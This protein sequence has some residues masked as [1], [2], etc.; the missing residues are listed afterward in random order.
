MDFYIDFKIPRTFLRKTMQKFRGYFL[1]HFFTPIFLRYFLHQFFYT[2]FFTPIFYI[3]FLR[4]FFYT[5]FL[6]QFFTPFFTPIIYTNFFT[7]FFTSTFCIFY[8]KHFN[9]LHQKFYGLIMKFRIIFFGKN[10][11]KKTKKKGVKMV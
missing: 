5:N 1:H 6:H 11:C 4:Q 10:W 8:T 9:F 3:N 7:L 2:N